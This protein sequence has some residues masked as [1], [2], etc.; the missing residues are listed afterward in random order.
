MIMAV[1]QDRKAH[2]EEQA[3]A[4]LAEGLAELSVVEVIERALVDSGALHFE[5]AQ[6]VADGVAI[7]L[8]RSGK[9]S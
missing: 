4:A 3:Q 5:E 9:L 6:E 2:I 1:D 7:Y 8:K